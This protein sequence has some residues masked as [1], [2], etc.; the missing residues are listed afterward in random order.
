MPM[1]D[2]FK[3]DAFSVTS[4]TDAIIKAPHKPGRIGALG[5]FREKGI[6]TTNVVIEEKDGRLSLI[7]A[8]PRGGAASSIGSAKRTARSFV[9]PHLE[10]ESVVMADEVQGV[11]SFGSENTTDAVQALINERLEDLRAMHEV[12][13]EYHRVGAIKGQILDADGSTV[14]FNLFTEFGV[15]Q[16][17][18]D[19][20]LSVAGTNVRNQAIAIQ[21]KIETELGGE[22]V[23]G[24][25]AFCG[26]TFFDD[27]VA[28]AKVEGALQYQ[29]SQLLRTD[30]RSGFEFG[31]IVWENY[32][33]KVLKPDGSASVDFFPAAEAYVVP[34]GPR[35]FSTAFAPADFME[36]VN[37]MGLPVYA[38]IAVDE[39]LNRWAKVHSQS[40]PMNL[41]LRPRAVVKVTKS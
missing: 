32:R 9:V 40:N 13:L 16:Q 14:L 38:K 1:L 24:Y 41:C 7:A 19:I 35:I 20:A 6:P 3:S 17:T 18:H 25:R 27:L 34:I 12:T 29:E 30:L 28:H 36:T 37:T 11:R 10:R 2:V 21:R 26:D 5:L 39:Q 31:G 33:G 8:T 23:T 22:P 4:L 15:A